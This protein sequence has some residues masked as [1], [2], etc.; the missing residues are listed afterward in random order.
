MKHPLAGGT[1][2]AVLVRRGLVALTVTGL[3]AVAFELATERH[4]HGVEQFRADFGP[5]SR[6]LAFSLDGRF[7][8]REHDPD[9]R[10]DSDFYVALNAW[11]EP[12]GFVVPPAPTRRRWRRVIDTARPGPDDF[13]P[14]ADGPVVAPGVTYPVAPF[15]V[16]E[17][18]SEG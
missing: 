2:G 18:V 9:Y 17:L 8:G 13:V 10:I 3:L 7:T 14:E 6:S 4:W 11:R 5:K 12:L 16:L 15:A 1:D